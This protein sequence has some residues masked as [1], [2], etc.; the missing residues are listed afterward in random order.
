[1]DRDEVLDTALIEDLT[2]KAILEK[3]SEGGE[4][5]RQR[6]QQ[7]KGLRACSQKKKKKSGKS[8]WNEME[9]VENRLVQ[10]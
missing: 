1:M 10:R 9:K 6:K 4:Q 5:S 8:G 3:R 7:V 2:E